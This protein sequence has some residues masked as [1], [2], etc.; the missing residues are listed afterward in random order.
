MLE[1]D[2]KMAVFHSFVSFK[3]LIR[4]FKQRRRRRLGKRF[5]ELVFLLQSSRLAG[6]IQPAKLRQNFLKLNM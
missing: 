1:G 2:I 6:C 4:E 3:E 5:F